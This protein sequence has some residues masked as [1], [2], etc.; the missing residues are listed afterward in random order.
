MKMQ[1]KMHTKSDKNDDKKI[2]PVWN[3]KIP[4]N[5]T[6]N[7]SSIGT[8]IKRKMLNWF[9]YMET[10]WQ[11]LYGFFSRINRFSDQRGFERRRKQEKKDR[12]SGKEQL[13]WKITRVVFQIEFK[14]KKMIV[15]SKNKCYYAGKE[16]GYILNILSEV[17]RKI[18][19]S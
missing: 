11:L 5:E 12:I 14:A 18:R 8:Y 19:C 13:L 6:K 9:R 15:L 2:L 1:G 17:T 16:G 10:V 4:V 7:A 3:S